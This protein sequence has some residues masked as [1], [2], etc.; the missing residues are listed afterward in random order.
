[1]TEPH[2]DVRL[3]EIAAEL[4]SCDNRK[5][6]GE[7]CTEL[8]SKP[9]PDESGPGIVDALTIARLNLSL[10][11]DEELWDIVRQTIIHA[12]GEEDPSTRGA[13]DQYLARKPNPSSDDENRRGASLGDIDDLDL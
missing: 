11:P 1:M 10:T 5:E 7:Y 6:L 4:F 3:T 9:V 8:A 13:R 2:D 12:G